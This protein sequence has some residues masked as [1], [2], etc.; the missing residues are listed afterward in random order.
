MSF[1]PIALQDRHLNSIEKNYSK[2]NLTTKPYLDNTNSVSKNLSNTTIRK[3]KIPVLHLKNL[4]SSNDPFI[5]S[6]R[7][8][9]APLSTQNIKKRNFS[10]HSP[11]SKGIRT[12]RAK[13]REMFA[14]PPRQIKYP[15]SPI[16]AVD[17]LK[18]V[19]SDMEMLEIHEYNEIYFVGSGAKKIY[20]DPNVCNYGYDNDKGDFKVVLGDHIDYRYEVVSL[21]GKGSFGQVCK[22]YD[23]KDK[24]LV[25]IKIIRNKKKFHKQGLVEVR[26]LEHM[27]EKDPLDRF[28]IVK[29]KNHFFFR[30]HLCIVFE[31]LSINLYEFIKS[32]NFQRVSLS[33]VARFAVQILISLQFSSSLGIIHCDLKPENILLKNPNKSGIK[34]IDFGSSCY[35]NQRFYNYIQSRFYRAPEIMLGIPYTCSIDMWSLA[36][37][38]IE[39]HIGQPIFPGKNEQEQFLRIMEVLGEPPL[40]ILAQ[41]TRKKLFF[42]SQGKAR[43]MPNS[44]GKMRFPGTRLLDDIVCSED[45]LFLGF[46]KEILVWDPKNRLTP[47]EALNHR[48]LKKMFKRKK[49][50]SKRQRVIRDVD[51][52]EKDGM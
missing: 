9:T 23:H 35:E 40:E 48:W 16:K 27:N 5:S 1:K 21:L 26:I 38:L 51:D 22:C 20:A 49:S 39:I 31:L 41:S 44:R 11:T 30:G 8:L 37:I 10:I 15:L 36:C 6:K 25:A 19:L 2:L 52:V 28:N 45:E 12:T 47:L 7:K 3:L 13:I 14:L 50:H 18:D 32:H 42:D 4:S 46:L 29:T 43:V 34:I 33:Y 24:E 17:M